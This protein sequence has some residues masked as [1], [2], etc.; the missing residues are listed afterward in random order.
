MEMDRREFAAE[1]DRRRRDGLV[2]SGPT[3]ELRDEIKA[4]GGIWDGRERVWLVPDRAAVQLMVMRAHL[5]WTLVLDDPARTAG[6]LARAAGAYKRLTGAADA[7]GTLDPER[8]RTFLLEGMHGLADDDQVREE[9]CRWSG[10]PGQ[11]VEALQAAG[12]LE[13]LERQ[14]AREEGEG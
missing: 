7:L 5:D 1:A 2:L 9:W 13:P 14:L 10:M 3:Y 4:A 11:L 8:D 6:L 12:D